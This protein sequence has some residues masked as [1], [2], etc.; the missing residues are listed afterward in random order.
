MPNYTIQLATTDKAINQCFSVMHEL[1]PHLQE[2]NFLNTIKNMQ[3]EGYRLAYI[4]HNTDV[5]AVAGYRIATN[6]FMGKHCYI[7][8]LVTTNKCRSL[9]YGE[10]LISWIREQANAHHCH[11]LHLDSGTHRGSAHKFYFKQG[12]VIASYHFSEAL[13]HRV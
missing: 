9:G 11:V 13:E 8:D 1:R 3:D 5:V 2:D 7:D 12:M 4:N 10:V 6:L